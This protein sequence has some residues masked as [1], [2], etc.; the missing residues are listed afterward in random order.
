MPT[1]SPEALQAE[2]EQ[3]YESLT[4]QAKHTEAQIELVKRIILLNLVTFKYFDFEQTKQLIS[5]NYKQHNAWATDGPDSIIDVAKW[6]Q[7]SCIENWTGSGE[8]HC[9]FQYKRILVDGEYVLC[10]FRG[11]R[12]P[13]DIG[14]YVWDLYRFQ[15]GK[16]A[17]HWDQVN[18]WIPDSKLKHPNGL[19]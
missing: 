9:D 11:V 5:P 10:Q 7:K 6:L 8:P 15:D 4:D 17:E 14:H 18:D 12:Y 1:P 2:V 19:M 16:W 13:G 3:V